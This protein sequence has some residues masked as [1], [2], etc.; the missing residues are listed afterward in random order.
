MDPWHGSRPVPPFP[1]VGGQR[2]S[3]ED[4]CYL[5]G[6]EWGADMPETHRRGVA[7]LL[8]RFVP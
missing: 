1:V 3:E 6:L 5:L 7:E 2:C 8:H 4:V